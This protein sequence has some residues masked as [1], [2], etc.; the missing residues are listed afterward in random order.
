M[1]ARPDRCAEA[2]VRRYPTW[3]VGGRRLE[4][5]LTL[6]EL[7]AASGFPGRPLR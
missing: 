7:A 5:V 4:G 6:D 2:G 3:V 1:G